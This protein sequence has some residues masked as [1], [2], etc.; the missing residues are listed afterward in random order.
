MLFTYESHLA[1]SVFL[2]CRLIIQT[3]RADFCAN[4]M[5]KC[6]MMAMT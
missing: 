4:K 5:H 1:H 2:G 3:V 6:H